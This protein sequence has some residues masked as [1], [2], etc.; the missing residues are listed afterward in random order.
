VTLAVAAGG[1]ARPSIGRRRFLNEAG[2]ALLALVVLIWSVLPIYNLFLIAL[3]PEEGEIEFTGNIWPSEPA[4]DA[5]YVVLT[6]T[7]R[8]LEQFWQQ[9]G[10]SV[11]IGLL[12]MVLTVLIGSSASFAVDRM[13]LGSGAALTNTALFTY[14]IPATFLAIPFSRLMHFYGLADNLWAAIAAQVT[15]ATPFAIL[16]LRRYA[17]LIPTELDDAARIDGAVVDAREVDADRRVPVPLRDSGVVH[18]HIQPPERIDRRLHDRADVVLP[19]CVA[20]LKARLP[21]DL[22]R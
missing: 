14:A 8:Y 4:L 18:H 6:Q 13:R 16:I 17:R 20:A 1:V 5:F 19:A 12:T 15:F 21:A 7:D 11:F 9:F 2:S 3:D 22:F 10:N